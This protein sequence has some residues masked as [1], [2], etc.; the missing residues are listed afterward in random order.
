MKRS[1]F[2]QRNTPVLAAPARA[3]AERP[4]EA[5]APDS[6][7]K[8]SPFANKTQPVFNRTTSMLWGYD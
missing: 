3:L 8:V 6:P 7:E 1:A 2:L 5:R 4:A